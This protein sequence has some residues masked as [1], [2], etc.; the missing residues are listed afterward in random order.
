MINSS[1][2]SQAKHSL[3]GVAVTYIDN[4]C[5]TESSSQLEFGS[6]QVNSHYASGASKSR[7]LHNVETDT[8]TA[9]HS[10][11]LAGMDPRSIDH[12]SYTGYHSTTDKGCQI[13]RHPRI[14]RH[15]S[16]PV[17]DHLFGK[18][19][20]AANPANRRITRSDLGLVLRP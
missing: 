19:T 1:T 12:G 10:T 14:N 15:R 6:L 9:N 16:G 4:I 3:H 8:T 5:G 20:Q 11:G 13:E 2:T 7:S 18:A 17:Q